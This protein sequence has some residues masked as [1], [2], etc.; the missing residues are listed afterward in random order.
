MCCKSTA[1]KKKGYCKKEYQHC[2]TK[3]AVIDDWRFACGLVLST[4][5][6]A[7]RWSGMGLELFGPV[8]DEM[9]Y[10]TYRNY[11]REPVR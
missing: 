2:E 11:G 4:M 7:V 10:G 5:M 1:K 9:M 3:D 8:L 6:F